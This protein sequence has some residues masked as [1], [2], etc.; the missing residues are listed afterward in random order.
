MVVKKS[1]NSDCLDWELW[2]M[3]PGNVAETERFNT[4]PDVLALQANMFLKTQI[5]HLVSEHFT[6]NFTLKITKTKAIIR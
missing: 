1:H 4:L 2:K 6:L 3:S 5:V